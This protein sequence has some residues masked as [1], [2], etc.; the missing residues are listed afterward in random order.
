MSAP[1]PRARLRGLLRWLLACALALACGCDRAGESSAPEMM[2]RLGT[3]VGIATSSMRA[4]LRFTKSESE[5]FGMSTPR[6]VWRLA[7]PRS[8]SMPTTL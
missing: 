6:Q 2:L 4:T 7:P 3:P 1:T 8:A 5:T